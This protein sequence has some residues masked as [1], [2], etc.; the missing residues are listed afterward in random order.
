[1]EIIKKE[2]NIIMTQK[3]TTSVNDRHYI[4]SSEFKG[5]EDT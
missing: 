1:M 5:N 3:Y 4:K 2:D